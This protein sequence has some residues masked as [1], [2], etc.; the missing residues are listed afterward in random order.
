VKWKKEEKNACNST[1]KLAQSLLK[2][3]TPLPTPEEQAT[4]RD[5]QKVEGIRLFRIMEFLA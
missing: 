1:E 3:Q 5:M 4:T 2:P